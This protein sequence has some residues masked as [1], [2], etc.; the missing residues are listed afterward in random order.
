[1][2]CVGGARS[3]LKVT[4]SSSS[5]YLVLSF[6]VLFN[7]VLL[8]S[9]LTSTGKCGRTDREVRVH[10][11]GGAEQMTGKCGTD[12][13]EVVGKQKLFTGQMWKLLPFGAATEQFCDWEVRKIWYFDLDAAC[14]RDWEVRTSKYWRIRSPLST[15]RFRKLTDR[16]VRFEESLEPGS[17]P[18]EE[19]A[20]AAKM[21]SC[22]IAHLTGKCG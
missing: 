22:A 9:L 14:K 4:L 17:A 21:N 18:V 7:H 12:D 6:L 2:R 20:S 11:P 15:P 13:W 3:L 8:A 5:P 19:I 1:M 16:E 10:G